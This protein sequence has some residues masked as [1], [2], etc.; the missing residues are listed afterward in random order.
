MMTHDE[1][2]A[3][4]RAHAEGKKIQWR[5]VHMPQREWEHTDE[6]SASA[7]AWNFARYDYRVAPEPRK[8]QRVWLLSGC[9]YVYHSRQDAEAAARGIIGEVVREFREVLDEKE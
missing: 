5:P 6:Q 9:G 2:I 3:V 8:A 7:P 1:M 4:I